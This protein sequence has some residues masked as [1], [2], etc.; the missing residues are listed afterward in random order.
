MMTQILSGWTFMR[1]VRLAL[2]M[3][4]T[5][6]SIIAKDWTLAL[7]GTG[8]AFMPLFNIGCCSTSSCS[9]RASKKNIT[10]ENI[11]YEEVS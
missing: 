10:S 3:V 8:F 5:V 11:T 4:I 2:A 6:Q 7:L 1:M 9:V